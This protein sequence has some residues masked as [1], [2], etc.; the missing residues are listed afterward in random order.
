MSFRS[1]FVA[2][3]IALALILGAFLI[4]RARPRIETDQPDAAFVKATGK[5]AECQQY[6]VVHEYEMSKHASQGVKLPRLS[7]AAK[8]AGARSPGP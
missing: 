3:T 4:Q 7:P 2:L 1:V 5:R 8:R 6:S